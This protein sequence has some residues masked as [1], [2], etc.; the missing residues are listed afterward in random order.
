MADLG[1]IIKIPTQRAKWV[2]AAAAKLEN[3]GLIPETHVTR[4]ERTTSSDPL[5]MCMEEGPYVRMHTR[6]HAHEHTHKCSFRNPIYRKW[7]WL[8]SKSFFHS[9]H[10]KGVIAASML[11]MMCEEREDSPH[12]PLN[13]VPSSHGACLP[14]V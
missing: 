10:G 11:Y 9:C 1:S 13:A 8:S 2:K 14:H 5:T 6:M 4:R 12:P 3:L 7:P